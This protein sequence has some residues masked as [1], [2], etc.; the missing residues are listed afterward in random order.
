MPEDFRRGFKNAFVLLT[1]LKVLVNN[2]GIQLLGHTCT[3]TTLFFNSSN[4]SRS[5]F[6]FQKVPM[7]KYQIGFLTENCG[8]SVRWQ[9]KL[10]SQL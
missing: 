8:L 6:V 9:L 2:Q 1:A 7:D 5:N 4:T 3:P 10:I